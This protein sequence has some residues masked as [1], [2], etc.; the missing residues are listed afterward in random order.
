MLFDDVWRFSQKNKPMKMKLIIFTKC[1][2]SE[3]I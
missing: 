1:Q 2:N 3:V